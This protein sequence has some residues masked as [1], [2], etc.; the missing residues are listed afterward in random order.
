MATA[1]TI[2]SIFAPVRVGDQQVIARLDCRIVSAEC[3]CS[4]IAV[5]ENPGV[6][7]ESTPFQSLCRQEARRRGHPTFR[8]ENGG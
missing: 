4:V 6:A 7:D 1:K 8:F 2:F 5:L 3:A